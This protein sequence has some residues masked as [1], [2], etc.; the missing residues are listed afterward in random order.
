M[1]GPPLSNGPVQGPPFGVPPGPPGPQ[2]VPRP[3]QS[4]PTTHPTA[5]FGPPKPMGPN[6]A[7]MPHPMRP[8]AAPS[9]GPPVPRYTYAI[10][11]FIKKE[12]N[13]RSRNVGVNF[14]VSN[15]DVMNFV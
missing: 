9:I 4:V 13:K 2:N 5:A 14:G 10:K 7:P 11:M 12:T 6:A 15:Y 3:Q 8:N 1:N